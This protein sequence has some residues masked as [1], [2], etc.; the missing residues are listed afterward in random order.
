MLSIIQF[1]QIRL[2]ESGYNL[3]IVL[4]HVQPQIYVFSEKSR[5]KSGEMLCT[6]ISISHASA[7]L[8][9]RKSTMKII[10]NTASSLT[11]S[12][13]ERLGITVLPVSVSLGSSSMRDYIDITPDKFVELLH[14][15]E[16][17]VSSQ[18]SVGDIMSAFENT[19]EDTLMLTVADGLSGEYMTAM[20]VRNSLDRKEH[21]HIINSRSL[22]GPLRYM[23]VRAAQLRDEGIS[24]Q[25][26]L[27]RIRSCAGSN[28]SFVIPADFNYLKK[29]GRINNMTSMIGGA[30]HLLPVLTQS[31]DHKRISFMTIRRTW[32]TAVATIISSLKSIG[33]DSRYLITVA[34]AEDR[35]LAC[36]VV[37]QIRE[38]FPE[39]QTEILQLAPSL[40]THGGPGC[41]VVQT[42]HTV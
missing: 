4:K 13:G 31:E 11:Q 24:P 35:D 39:T 16:M 34:Y 1:P 19:E 36:R 14:G 3:I 15:D 33:V 42:V 18:P 26:I 21:I 22:A 41:I 7:W 6:N 23:A 5:R 10:T 40:I 20:G 37:K 12:D 8:K 2:Q 29:S 28:V 38:S 17:P 32:K 9:K 30:L 27:D 25:E